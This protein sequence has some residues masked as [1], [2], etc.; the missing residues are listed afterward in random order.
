MIIEEEV[1]LGLEVIKDRA[2]FNKKMID[3]RIKEI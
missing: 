3:L 2:E 1:G